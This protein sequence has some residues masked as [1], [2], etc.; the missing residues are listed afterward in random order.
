MQEYV[1]E[2]QRG[3]INALQSSLCHFFWVLLSILGMVFHK[4]ANFHILVLVS[5]LVVFA[6]SCIFSWWAAKFD[7]SSREEMQTE[8]QQQV[9]VYI[10]WS[11]VHRYVYHA[12]ANTGA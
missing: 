5:V 1:H 11:W 7:T 9:L 4:P 12:G 8:A 2:E 3:S 10:A 6:A